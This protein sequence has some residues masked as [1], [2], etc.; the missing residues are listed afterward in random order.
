M[1]QTLIRLPEFLT[2]DEVATL[3]GKKRRWIQVL[4]ARG[5]LKGSRLVDRGEWQI[6]PASVAK[7]LGITL[8]E[9]KRRRRRLA[10][11]K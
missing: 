8:D 10:R 6:T 4:V 1:P 2:T 5:Q 11:T 7:C 3:T 9:L